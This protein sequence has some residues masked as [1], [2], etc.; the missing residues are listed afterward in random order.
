M[1]QE[2]M[3]PSEETKREIHSMQ[4]NLMSTELQVS[5]NIVW[6]KCCEI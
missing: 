1:K 2:Q 6:V 4:H 5:F 3:N